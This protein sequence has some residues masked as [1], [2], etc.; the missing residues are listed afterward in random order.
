MRIEFLPE[1]EKVGPQYILRPESA[2]EMRFLT[3]IRDIGLTPDI[4][5]RVVG[6]EQLEKPVA[7]QPSNPVG[8]LTLQAQRK[9][10][11]APRAAELRKKSLDK[12]LDPAQPTPRKQS[13]KTTVGQQ[14]SARGMHAIQAGK[15]T[16]IIE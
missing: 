15:R 10:G 14:S 4:V 6:Q 8:A 5:F 9:D 1:T 16:S 3:I 13:A 2:V 11:K 12:L 7:G